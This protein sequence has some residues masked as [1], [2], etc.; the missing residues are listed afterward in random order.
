[1]E[2][3]LEIATIKANTPSFGGVDLCWLISR[4]QL[5][6]ILQDVTVFQSSPLIT[7]A[8]YQ[9]A[10]LPI[11]N[12]EQ[13]FGLPEAGPGKASKYLVVRAVTTE[14]ALV[15]VIIK[16]PNVLKIQQVEGVFTAPRPLSLPRN[17]ADL[18]GSYSMPDGSLGLF[19]DVAGISRS[20]NWGQNQP[21]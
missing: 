20:L 8:E 14:K 12:L 11:I 13:H 15:K 6:F 17:N 10:I 16:T 21:I 9:D 19:P 18:M 4:N 7:T 5:E 2:T 1:M 3:K